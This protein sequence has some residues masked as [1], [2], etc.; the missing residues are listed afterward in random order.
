MKTRAEQALDE[1]RRE[2]RMRQKHF[3]RWIEQGTLRSDEAAKRMCAL[4]IAIELIEGVVAAESPQ[5]TL[6]EMFPARTEE[7]P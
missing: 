5:M 3:P 4:Q 2:L 6:H 1:L 7:S